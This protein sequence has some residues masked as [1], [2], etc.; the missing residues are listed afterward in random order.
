MR[1]QINSLKNKE[2]KENKAKNIFKNNI[3]ENGQN[4]LK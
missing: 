3:I 4:S 2:E 1:N